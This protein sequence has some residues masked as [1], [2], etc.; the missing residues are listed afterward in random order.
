[1]WILF[2]GENL[3]ALRFKSS[4]VVLKRS[5]AANEAAES[6]SVPRDTFI[7]VDHA[8]MWHVQLCHNL[9]KLWFRTEQA[10]SY[11]SKPML[12]FIANTLSNRIHWTFSKTCRYSRE[13]SS[14]Y[15]LPFHRHLGPNRAVLRSCDIWT[16]YAHRYEIWHLSCTS[17]VLPVWS[18]Y[19]CMRPEFKQQIP[20]GMLYL[21][22]PWWLIKWKHLW[23]FPRCWPF[24]RGIH[25]ST[26]DSPHKGQWSGALMF[27]LMCAWTNGLLYKPWS[28]WWFE[29]RWYSQWRHCN[30]TFPQT[31]LCANKGQMKAFL[32]H[33]E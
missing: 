26:V 24:M 16:L 29:T 31:T 25:R 17:I 3:R 21:A 12:I 6:S 33:F 1:M 22:R 8:W 10:P 5:L 19:S 7:L 14:N 28:C 20:W 18:I 2:T 27:S 30:D 4:L 15:R 13:H 11:S 9:S 32:T 23:H